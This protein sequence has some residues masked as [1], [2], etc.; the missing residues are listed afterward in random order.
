MY[1]STFLSFIFGNLS[2]VASISFIQEKLGPE[3][4]EHPSRQFSKVIENVVSL[5]NTE[6]VIISDFSHRGQVSAK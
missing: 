1:L 3:K 4:L 6:L 5:E 2:S